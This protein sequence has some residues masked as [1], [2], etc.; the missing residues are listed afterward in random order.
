[1]KI[2]ISQL[3]TALLAVAMQEYADVPTEDLIEYTFSQSFRQ[4]AKTL[5]S[6]SQRKT[7]RCWNVYRQRMILIAV[8]V[9]LLAAMVSCVPM[10][11][12][13]FVRYDFVDHGK[14][15]SIT[16]DPEQAAKAPDHCETYYV[17][18]WE[19]DGYSLMQRSAGT[20]GVTYIWMNEAEEVI[21]YNQCTIPKNA[22][23]TSWY[24]IDSEH[25]VRSTRSINGYAVELFT[26]KDEWNGET[27]TTVMAVWTDNAYLYDIT[28]S[29]AG[30][31]NL[32]IIETIMES[33]VVVEA[34]E[35]VDNLN[36]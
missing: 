19:P 11:R 4:K 17:P 33:L 20:I 31:G 35:P 3:K 10:I 6:K 1:M 32:K 16:F 13:R 8:I 18:T 24:T 23:S 34:V 14:F 36:K 25:S 26:W 22:T 7:W 29:I 9:A 2:E 5:N 21:V 28:V 27:W 30:Q 15:Y 12:K